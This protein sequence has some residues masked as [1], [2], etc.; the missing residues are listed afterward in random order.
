MVYQGGK[1]K[2]SKYIIPFI[3]KCIKENNIQNYYEPFCG[4][5]NVLDKVICLNRYANDIDD[6][7]IEFYKYIKNGGYPLENITREDY[8]NIKNGANKVARGNAKYL[9]S[10]GGKPW[11]GY[12]GIDKRAPTKTRYMSSLTTFKK[13]IPSILNTNFTSVNY[14]ELNFL[15]NSFIYLD[16]PYKNTTGYLTEINYQEYYNWVL[17]I[18][19]NNYVIASEYNMPSDFICFYKIPIKQSLAANNN[20]K[21]ITDNLYYCNGLFKDWFEKQGGI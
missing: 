4:G 11:G 5:L 1:T 21:E 3:N 17:E 9:A 18:S 12:S 16:P 14:K 7:L 19:K 15:P 20:K 8:Y 13:Q 2:Q 10:F 6:E